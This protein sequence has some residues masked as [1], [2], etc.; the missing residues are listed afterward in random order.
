MQNK[1]SNILNHNNNGNKKPNKK[2][3]SELNLELNYAY[4]KI[5]LGYDNKN[6]KKNGNFITRK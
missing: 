6:N 1:K 5:K 3:F 4:R 2:K